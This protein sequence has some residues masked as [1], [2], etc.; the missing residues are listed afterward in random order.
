MG[1]VLMSLSKVILQEVKTESIIAASQN[2]LGQCNVRLVF[3]FL[4]MYSTE[5]LVDGLHRT[6]K[7]TKFKSDARN[8][9]EHEGSW[10][11]KC[12][13]QNY[14]MQRAKSHMRTFKSYLACNPTKKTSC[15]TT[16]IHFWLGVLRLFEITVCASHK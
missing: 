15:P 14:H 4:H 7:T 12:R 1:L 16:K 10:E 9:L 3:F 5:A 6:Q 11:V 2:A 8:F 13:A